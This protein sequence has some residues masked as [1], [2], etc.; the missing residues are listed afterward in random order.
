LETGIVKFVSDLSE[1]RARSD[2][3]KKI[4]TKITASSPVKFVTE[5]TSRERGWPSTSSTH[6]RAQCYKTFS[7]VICG[8]LYLAIVFVRLDQ[9]SLPMTSPLAYYENP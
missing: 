2:G 5:F 4:L 1:W 7:V 8:F 6:T 3:T 9:K